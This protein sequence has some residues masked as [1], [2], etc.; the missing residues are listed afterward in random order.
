MV[1]LY[2]S[3]PPD[4]LAV[5]DTLLYMVH[6]PVSAQTIHTV[7]ALINFYD[8][9]LGAPAV[10]TW[11]TTINKGWFKPWPQASMGL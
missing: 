10:R 2:D 3:K 7:P 11:L 9:T 1:E 8:A 6:I 4:T 5:R